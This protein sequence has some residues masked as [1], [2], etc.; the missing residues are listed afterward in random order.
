MA[1][2]AELKQERLDKLHRL[3]SLGYSGFAVSAGQSHTI[4]NLVS[5]FDEYEASQAEITVTG[6]V[7]AR[8]GHGK[9]MFIDLFD[10]TN[11][12]QI[13]NKKD[14]LGDAFNH[15][16]DLID[17]GDFISVTGVAT[18]TKRGEPS[19]YAKSW[20]LVTKSL[21]PLPDSW[22]GLKDDD[23]RYRNRHLDLL[24]NPELRD[25]FVKKAKFWQAAREFLIT[26]GF[27]EVHTPT[28]ETTTGGAEA[29]PFITHHNDFDIDVYLRI[30][31]GELWQKRLM[32]AGFPRTF[33]MGRIY[34]NEGSS[35]EHL[36][37]FNNIEFQPLE[38]I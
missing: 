11:T 17:R 14:E 26:E 16:E 20:D 22:D 2:L 38:L 30:S 18:K 35:P 12:I 33:E 29:S 3:E 7:M 19:I 27:I 25:L 24:Q 23:L 32:A 6:R 37:E 8:R 15:L 1:S 28:L 13:Y 36:Q 4:S 10:G 31:V 9:L 21:A 34:R 5:N